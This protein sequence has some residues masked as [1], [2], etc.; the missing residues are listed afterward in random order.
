MLTQLTAQ[1]VREICRIVDECGELWADPEAWQTHL[2]A[3]TSKLIRM[4]IGMTALVSN[5]AAG[6][7]P[8]VC[9]ATEHG[10]SDP[11]QHAIMFRIYVE[12][13]TPAFG[14]APVDLRFRRALEPGAVTTR[15]RPNLL[16]RAEWHRSVAYNEYFGPAS[17]REVLYSAAHMPDGKHH[18]LSFGGSRVADD[19]ARELVGL[20]HSEIAASLGSRLA[21]PGQVCLYGLT[22]RQREVLDA[23]LR[24]ISEKEIAHELKLSI[25]RVNE[26]LQ[27]LYRHFRVNSRAALLAYLLRRAPVARP[28]A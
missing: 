16:P 17:L 3:Q 8:Q 13:K 18:L 1:D 10:W 2:L 21:I 4:P 15:S 6:K 9:W 24:G 26:H 14:F 19:R 5:F 23:A 12:Q 22:P 20:L 7:A 11:A 28:L 25:A 27:H